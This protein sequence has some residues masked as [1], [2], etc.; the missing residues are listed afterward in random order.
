MTADLVGQPKRFDNHHNAFGFLRLLL[1]SLVIV[2]HVPETVG[3]SA[4]R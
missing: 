4:R 1:A 3:G 2:S